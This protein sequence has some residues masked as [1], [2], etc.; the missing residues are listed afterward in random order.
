MS[1]TTLADLFKEFQETGG[2]GAPPAVEGGVYKLRCTDAFVY[3]EGEASTILGSAVI[4]EGP[5][6]GKRVAHGGYGTLKGEGHKYAFV[7]WRQ[8][9]LTDEWLQSATA[10]AGSDKH[11]LLTEVA[12]AI[13]GRVYEATLVV[14]HYNPEE[15][16][17]KIGKRT[18][19]TLLA[20]PP[21]PPLGGVPV[22]AAPVAQAPVAPAPVAAAPAPVA[23]PV[24]AVAAPVAAV[25]PAVAVAPV[26]VAPAPVAAVAPLAEAVAAA[27]APVA[28]PAPVAAVAAPVAA[29]AAPVAAAAPA[30]PLAVAAIAT[31]DEPGF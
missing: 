26:A 14:D 23:A 24:A 27:V 5:L 19:I 11:T 30:A 22:G 4:E 10:L 15:P 8:L 20:A 31:D 7:L 21:L 2:G 3:G 16:R 18:K 6:V 28:A 17:N 1:T 12:K 25:A 13:V 29:A 9:G